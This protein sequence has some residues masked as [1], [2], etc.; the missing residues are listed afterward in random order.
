[1]YKIISGDTLLGIVE[2]PRYVRLNNGVF[3]QCDMLE[4]D[5]VAFNSTF[6]RFPNK[7]IEGYDPANVVEVDGGEYIV[8]HEEKL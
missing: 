8:D 2:E 3:I 6:Y 7:E 4:A 5:G 1:M